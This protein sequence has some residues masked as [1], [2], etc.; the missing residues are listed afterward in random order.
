M[1]R[2]LL[3]LITVF[4]GLHL[5][6]S[7]EKREV[8][9]IEFISYIMSGIGVIDSKQAPGF[10]DLAQNDPYYMYVAA[11]KEHG[12]I[13][14]Y[15]GNI[16][17]PYENIKRE[18]ALVILA[19]AYEIKPVSDR[20][21]KDFADFSEI[22]EYSKGYISA[23]VQ[24]NIIE[25]NK[26]EDFNP[27]GYID[28]DEMQKLFES[29][30]RY[31]KD[32]MHFAFGYPKISSSKTYNAITLSLK[33]SRPS[34]VYYKLVPVSNYLGG[35]RP[36]ISELNSFLTAVSMP[37][38]VVDVNIY[39]EDT[40]EYNIYIVAVDNEGN[41]TDVEF[42][43]NVVSH[44]YSVGNGSEKNPYRIYN[45]EQLC[46]I[47]YYPTAHF[48]LEADI[49]IGGMWE[50]IDIA[51]GFLGFAGVLDGNHHRITG[52]EIRK[53]SKNSGLFSVIYG[54]KVKN[55]YIDATVT[56]NE[57]AGIITGILEGGSIS[58][59]F[60]TGRVKA[61]G[62]NAGG[63]VGINNGEIRDCVS[64]AYMV[65]AGNYAG[66]IAGLNKGEILNSISAVYTVSADMY[67]SGVAGVNIGGRINKN[68]CANIYAAD[69]ITTKSGRVTTNKQGGT[70][71]GNYCYDKMMSD[72]MVSFGE[73]TQ[74]GQEVSWNELVTVDFYE[75]V[76]G[77]DVNRIWENK[78]TEDFR[79]LLPRGFGAPE[80]AKG[81][82]MYAPIKVSTEEELR[83]V[84]DNPDMHYIL[85]NDI[86]IRDKTKWKMIGGTDIADE[87]SGFNGTFDGNNHTIS[88]LKIDWEEKVFGM[89]GVISAGTVR[90]LKLIN[91]N[92]DAKSLAGGISGVNYGYIENCSVS[93]KIYIEGD[94]TMLSAGGL[95]GNNY[96]FLENIDVN[97][98]IIALGQVATVGG[99][100]ANNEG[101]I[102]N[103]NFSGKLISRENIIHSN[104]VVGGIAG[105]NTSGI[106]Y[107]SFSKPEITTRAYVNYVGGTAG[108]INGGEIYKNVALGNINVKSYKDKETFAYSGGIAGLSPAGL[109]MNSYSLTSILVEA[110]NVY[111][112]GIC[113][114]N[115][116]SSIQNNYSMNE[117]MIEG[118]ES[119]NSNVY[120]GGISGYSEMGFI[121]DNAVLLKKVLANGLFAGVSNNES[122]MVSCENN[123]IR[124][125]I[126]LDTENPYASNGKSFSLEEL[127]KEDF[128]FKP[129]S[130]GG[131]LGWIEGDVWYIEKGF[132]FPKL[133]G[134]K[135]QDIIK[136]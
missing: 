100:A 58:E 66:G 10:L 75:D 118:G 50:P 85:T 128:F 98:Q 45:K 39:P 67:A 70:T 25:C 89:F 17:K 120:T 61:T 55:L 73:E 76:M 90:N 102:D 19:R 31:K 22:S 34:T 63:I 126:M 122:E 47:K 84:S 130:E 21:I 54:G 12:V 28:I 36:N 135:N 104:A 11:A 105:I 42:I 123:Y 49:N 15:V 74:D 86:S 14:G 82:T 110:N 35:F 113:G 92:I 4:F 121:H 6:V 69:I 94:G 79:L 71:K 30:E 127:K 57:N 53:Y 24:K 88:G 27:K 77:W 119:D 95:V 91:L 38:T 80:M 65:E 40:Q 97:M 9:R 43:E 29:F 2:I 116:N 109:I 117:L 124:N 134:V 64:A 13:T 1:K 133:S 18:D 3:F 60:V 132:P 32:S 83:S 96:G 51:E 48:K 93:G 46:G 5:C 33:V 99:V 111:A 26:D 131:A 106:I 23:A 87:E 16:L 136:M 72:S 112:G 20:Y 68:V 52:M 103:A 44:R 56:G 129:I 114:Y 125:D 107:N 101:Y 8:K 115:Q 7:A 41:Y 81:I 78:I 108:I 62:N 59:C 37:N